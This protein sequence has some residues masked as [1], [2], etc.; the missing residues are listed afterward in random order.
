M[1]ISE[2]SI[3]SIKELQK[4]LKD[5][6]SRIFRLDDIAHLD[7]S[8]WQLLGAKRSF[9]EL[10]EEC[11]NDSEVM[12]I[13]LNECFG[14]P[15]FACSFLL[16]VDSL[17]FQGA[18]I[19]ETWNKQFVYWLMS[20]G[21]SKSFS[22]AI[23]ALL[24]CILIPGSKV[25][26]VSGSF[27]QSKHVF[28]YIMDVY[29]RSPVLRQISY[30][31]EPKIGAD[32]CRFRVG[33]STVVCLPLGQGET[34]RG[35]R[36]NVIL[37]D[38]VVSINPDVFQTVII[39]FAAVAMNP[40]EK[41]RRLARLKSGSEIHSEASDIFDIGNQII[42]SGTAGY[43][44]THAYQWYS[45]YQ[46]IIKSKADKEVV[47]K[48]FGEEA[49]EKNSTSLDPR[50]YAVLTLPYDQ[51]PEGFMEESIISYAKVNMADEIFDAEFKCLWI[52]D[53]AGFIPRSLIES[54]SDGKVCAGSNGPCVMGVDP[55]K[56]SDNF[57]ITISKID[58][59]TLKVIYCWSFNEKRLKEEFI[60]GN[61]PELGFYTLAAAKILYLIKK[62]NVRCIFMDEGGGGSAV[63]EVLLQPKNYAIPEYISNISVCRHDAFP[64]PNGALPML[65]IESTTNEMIVNGFTTWKKD[66]QSDKV[67]FAYPNYEQATHVSEEKNDFLQD[68]Y[69]FL[70]KE[71]EDMKREISI[72]KAIPTGR[73]TI[74]F[75]TDEKTKS[76]R[77]KKDRA[78]CSLYCYLAWKNV[79]IIE[80]AGQINYENYHVA[81]SLVQYNR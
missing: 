42:L 68:N 31:E 20:R 2:N 40:N 10:I 21:A 79:G 7:L 4:T 48:M 46:S 13:C 72:V 55:A 5:S 65:Y 80:N 33:T 62:F 23:Y 51:I 30:P 70:N 35:E 78:F 32:A 29:N 12:T 81:G 3:G 67:K 54:H 19:K 18:M 36:A 57:A 74:V 75:D 64:I 37:V 15:I 73:N 28:R 71:I 59:D 53:S 34:L 50:N 44:F 41:V 11:K 8:N 63:E 66:I 61:L 43:E 39:G 1:R 17:P 25:V 69:D 26:I 38:E 22:L 47:K 6:K 27:R 16:G 9:S 56:K 76:R 45:N 52:R 60:L 77:P 49:V 24:R 58:G 14:N